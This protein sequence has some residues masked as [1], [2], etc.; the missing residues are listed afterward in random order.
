MVDENVVTVPATAVVGEID[1]AVRSGFE[2][3]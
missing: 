1:P 2:L 3:L